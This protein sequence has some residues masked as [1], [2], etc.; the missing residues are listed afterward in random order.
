[1][2]VYVTDDSTPPRAGSGSGN[3][4]ADAAARAGRERTDRE[5][6]DRDRA[7]RERAAAGSTAAGQAP[8]GETPAGA[9]AAGAA[10]AGAAAPGR[11]GVRRRTARV[12]DGDAEKR[13]RTQR[14]WI[15]GGI[16]GGAALIILLGCLLV[17]GLA[18]LGFRL[19]DRVEEAELRHSTTSDACLDL[20]ARLN[21][22]VP[23]GATG[24]DPGRRAAAIRDENVAVRL[25][26]ADVDDLGTS[27]R[28]R[29]GEPGDLVRDWQLLVDARTAYANA[30]DRQVTAGEPAFFVTPEASRGRSVVDELLRASPDSCDGS[31]RRLGRPDL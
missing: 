30:L 28:N 2:T 9:A 7:D 15:I 10:A 16:A 14:R 3:S 1:L 13:D 31:V 26:L 20:E 24:G 12:S 23:P 22:L 5:R 18:R 25:F 21:R 29:D 19:A 6:T 17:G 8:G 27:Q 11:G 4:D